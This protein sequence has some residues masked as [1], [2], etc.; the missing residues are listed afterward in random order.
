[1]LATVAT[2]SASANALPGEPLYGVKQAQEELGVRLAHDDQARTLVLLGQADA[3]LDEAARL[4]QQG[5]TDQVAQT[6]QRFDDILDR[7]TTT[8]VVTIAEQPTEARLL[9]TC[10]L[11]PTPLTCNVRPTP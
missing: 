2:L 6:T 9:T 4:L 7:A 1:M 11:Q 10:R 3:R 8:F 5:R